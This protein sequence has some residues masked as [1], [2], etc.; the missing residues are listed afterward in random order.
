MKSTKKVEKLSDFEWCKYL[1]SVTKNT[2]ITEV[3]KLKLTTN[4]PSTVMSDWF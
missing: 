4:D 1:L 3:M 2:G